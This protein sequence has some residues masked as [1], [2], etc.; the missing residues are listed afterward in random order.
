MGKTFTS[1]LTDDMV[2]EI[3]QIAEIEKLASFE[4][5]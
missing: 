1:C 3:E 5:F 2:K 4:D